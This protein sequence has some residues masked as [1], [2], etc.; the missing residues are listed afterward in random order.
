MEVTSLADRPDLGEAFYAPELDPGPTFAYHDPVGVELWPRLDED[1]ADYQLALL[2]DGK[3]IAKACSIPLRWEGT[4]EE[5][6]DE[7][8]D[9]ALQRGVADFQAGREPN[10]L[11]A[12]WIVV[13]SER[14]G[15]G[16]SSRMVQSLRDVAISHD[17]AV[18]YAPVAPTRKSDYPLI[19]MQDYIAWTLTDGRSPFDPWLRVHWKIGGRVLHVCSR[20]MVVTGT[21][22]D[23]QEW[24][25]LPMPGSG[26][27]VVSRALAPVDVDY[28][29][30]LVRYTEP[31]VWVRHEVR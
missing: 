11:C 26:Q 10:A 12:L 15:T 18:L 23:W 28:Q 9:F 1:F 13:S 5:L 24:T 30:D 29:R 7:G 17:L 21:V 3:V 19:E 22:A 8:W 25:G 31:N 2:D 6:P 27:Y 20:S 16:L 4:D 14:R